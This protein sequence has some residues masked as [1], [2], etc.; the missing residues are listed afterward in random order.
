MGGAVRA[1]VQAEAAASSTRMPSEAD[2]WRRLAAR[3][4]AIA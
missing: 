2:A 3:L 4:R 1:A